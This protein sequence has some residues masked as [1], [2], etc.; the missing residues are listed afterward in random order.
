MAYELGLPSNAIKSF[1]L[2][3]DGEKLTNAQ[4][5]SL[6]VKWNIDNFKI[7]GTLIF[8]DASNLVE[9]H[10]IRGNNTFVMA[11]TDFDDV[12]SKQEFKTNSIRF[13]QQTLRSKHK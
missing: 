13:I 11:L 12:V 3:I 4:V 9:N 8:N 2:T 1:D 6:K 5:I 7:V 10:P